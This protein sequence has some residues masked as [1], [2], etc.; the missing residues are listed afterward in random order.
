MIKIFPRNSMHVHQ[1]RNGFIANV[2]G[3]TENQEDGLD[4]VYAL[5]RENRL[6]L[7]KPS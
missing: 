2:K 5:Q 4:S 6:I 3:T 1:A 7:Q